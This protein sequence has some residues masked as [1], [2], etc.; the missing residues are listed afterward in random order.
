MELNTRNIMDYSTSEDD[1]PKTLSPSTKK[2]MVEGR[3]KKKL[4]TLEAKLKDVV[5]VKLLR[6]KDAEKIIKKSDAIKKKIAEETELM[7]SLK[8]DYE[9]KM[10]K[11]NE[12]IAKFNDELDPI[13]DKINKLAKEEDKLAKSIVD[14]AKSI[15][16]TGDAS[17]R[18]VS[19]SESE[20]DNT[21]KKTKRSI[22]KAIKTLVWNKYIGENKA[23]SQCTCCEVTEIKNTHFHCGHVI[24][25][26]AGGTLEISN[27]RPICA[28]CNL[29][30]GTQ[31]MNTFKTTFGLGVTSLKK[32]E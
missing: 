32:K 17:K 24:S 25:E 20:S 18:E 22:P 4:Q 3:A 14:A 27:L 7:E 5:D 6:I 11:F 28:P 29:S 9:K 19:T 23:S 13:Q 2:K 26:S 15:A 21:G 12:N 8:A 16:S 10:K 31:N 30:M 1:S